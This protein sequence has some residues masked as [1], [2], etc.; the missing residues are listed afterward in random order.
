METYEKS[1]PASLR[2]IESWEQF[3]AIK[4]P[5][6]LS[7]LLLRSNGTGLYDKDTNKELQVF[8]TQE[9]VE[10]FSAFEF[11]TY[12]SDAIP[13]SLDGCS[14]IV[15][16]K[17]SDTGIVGLY[18]M[19]LSNLGWEDSKYLGS[20]FSQVVEMSETVDSVLNS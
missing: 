5:S 7:A 11:Q 2:D 19:A 18:A 4:M 3:F 20:D 13:V 16:Y 10:A 14:N 9:A 12:C 15:V 17:K 6:D 8:S 1:G